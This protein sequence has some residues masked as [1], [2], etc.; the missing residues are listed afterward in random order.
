M[1]CS[2]LWCGELQ[3]ITSGLSFDSHIERK[4][5]MSVDLPAKALEDLSKELKTPEELTRTRG[6]QFRV[7]ASKMEKE[8]KSSLCTAPGIH[9]CKNMGSSI[10]CDKASCPVIPKTGEYTWCHPWFG[11]SNYT[12]EVYQGLFK[13]YVPSNKCK[14]ENELCQGGFFCSKICST[15]TKQELAKLWMVVLEKP[16]KLAQLDV[17]VKVKEC[18]CVGLEW[19]PLMDV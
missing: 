8:S 14:Y 7:A 15:K 4:H 11:C 19:N 9:D 13:Q 17:E 1:R 18:E 3:S 2:G 6:Q 5:E 16:I 10:K 12:I